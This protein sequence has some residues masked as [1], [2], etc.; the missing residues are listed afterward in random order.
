MLPAPGAV[1][2]T[3]PNTRAASA[4]VIDARTGEILYEKNADAQRPIASTQKLLTALIVAER[5]YLDQSVAVIPSD[6]FA[7]PTKLGFKA[8]ESYTRMDLLRVLLVHSCNDVARCLARDAGGSI[9][10]FASMMNQKARALGATSSNFENPNGLPMPGQYSTARDL[11]RIARAAYG[12]STIRS[13]VSLPHMVFRYADG[14][15]REFDNTNK[16]LR[17]LPYCNG[18]KTGYTDAA[19]HCLVSSATRPGRDV[20]SIVLGDPKSHVW[21]DSAALLTWGLSI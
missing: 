7:E 2:R 18:M 10:T 4:I 13:V 11:S 1:P 20:I 21:I 15:T 8:G 12:N 19:G 6:T 14:H 3:P 9:E 5:G 17:R 16:V